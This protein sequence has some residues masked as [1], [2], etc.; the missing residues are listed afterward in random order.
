MFS[1]IFSIKMATQKLTNFD[2]FFKKMHADMT[3]VTMQS[4]K[5]VLNEV[6]DN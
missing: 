1:S 3:V 4:N 5:I 2:K 6:K